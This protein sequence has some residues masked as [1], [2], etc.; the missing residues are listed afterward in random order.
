[1][2]LPVRPPAG[3]GWSRAA[4]VLALLVVVPTWAVAGPTGG[5]GAATS[6][7]APPA[8]LAWT[9]CTV[10]H[11]LQCGTVRVPLRY[12]DPRGAWLSVA[13][14][15]APALDPSRRIG[16]LFFNPGGPGES[17][18]E[19][20]PVVLGAFPAQVR[21]RFD[22]VSFDPRGTGASERLDCGTSTSGA[23]SQLPVP[24]RPGQPLP[25]TPF[26]TTM[27]RACHLEHAQLT[28]SLDS[29]TTARDM[30]R[31]RQALGL[32]TIS[33]YGMSYGTVLGT[34]YAELFP[35]RLRAMVLD[36]AVDLDASLPVQ[37]AEQAPAAEASVVHVLT[38]CGGESPCPLGA[39][40]LGA[41]TALSASLTARPLPAPGA[42][43]DVPVTVGDLDAATLFAVTVPSLTDGYLTAL[44]AARAGDGS[45][46]R[47]LALDL[48]T[49]VDGSS[50][51]DPQW[52]IACNDAP[53]HPG[54]RAAGALARTLAAR[55]PLIGGYVA[56]YTLAGCVAWPAASRPVEDV[57]PTGAPPTLVIGNT[58]DPNTPLV[59]ARHLAADYPSASQ[60][61]WD[62]WGHTWLLSGAGDACMQRRVASYLLDRT[63]PPPRTV[64]P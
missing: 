22:I 41:F 24:A 18:L 33:Y 57:H 64:C 37:A 26:F 2:T 17:G 61:T 19:L 60:L 49:D 3:S 34:V 39:D 12:D 62:G 23:T 29:T 35:H 30:D 27:A 13:V 28:A 47:Q 14:T 58:G 43:D 20:L 25:A 53:A 10:D 9:T 59:A 8:P 6:R 45:G 44:A 42:G 4:L 38:G 46:L 63:L 1:M 56:N 15:R 40:P 55:D 7:P 52:A 21:Q 36:G 50:L 48:V 31:I 51:V 5:A 11:A 16:T 54:P 32:A